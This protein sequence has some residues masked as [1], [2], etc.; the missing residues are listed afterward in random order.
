MKK[1]NRHLKEDNLNIKIWNE[2]VGKS[3]EA[4]ENFCKK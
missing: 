3:S 4:L 2:A 1:Q